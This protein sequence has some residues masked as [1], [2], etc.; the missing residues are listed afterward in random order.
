MP[1]LPATR[2]ITDEKTHDSLSISFARNKLLPIMHY[3]LY[4]SFPESYHMSSYLGAQTQEKVIL[5]V[6]LACA[7]KRELLSRLGTN[8][9]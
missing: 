4:L 5:C 3:A 1:K 6:F 2:Q 9:V 7:Q 8:M